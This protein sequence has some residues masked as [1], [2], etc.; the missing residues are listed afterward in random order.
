MHEVR[1]RL[2]AAAGRTRRPVARIEL[3][4]A[5]PP[6]RAVLADCAEP[7]LE[8]GNVPPVLHDRHG[9]A[10]ARRRSLRKHG[11]A[12]LVSVQ[13]VVPVET[14]LDVVVPDKHAKKTAKGLTGELDRLPEFACGLWPAPQGFDRARHA[15]TLCIRAQGMPHGSDRY[16]RNGRQFV[17]GAR[18]R[19]SSH[20]ERHGAEDRRL[21]AAG[22]QNQKAFIRQGAEKASRRVA[23]ER[24]ESVAEGMS[25]RG[26]CAAN[27]MIC[28]RVSVCGSH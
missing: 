23:V 27:N 15:E 21:R 17:R 22:E 20:L 12:R 19:G 7:G 6:P 13:A 10:H 18:T 9:L 11:L 16:R 5:S 2:R 25:G 1:T 3:V 4:L 24:H 14:S 8:P 28:A 26:S